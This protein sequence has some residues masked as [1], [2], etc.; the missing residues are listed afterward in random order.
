MPFCSENR[1]T[2]YGEKKKINYC[3]QQMALMKNTNIRKEVINKQLIKRSS[4][5]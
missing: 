1:K 5:Y 4:E 3:Y 2:V